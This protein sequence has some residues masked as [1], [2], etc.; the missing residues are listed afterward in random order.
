MRQSTHIWQ[1]VYALACNSASVS[2]SS[3]SSSSSSSCK[4][5]NIWCVGLNYAEHVKELGSVAAT[6]NPL[7]FLKAGSSMLA[8]GAE[9]LLPSWSEN[10]HH[11][12]ELAIEVDANLQPVR[13]AVSLDLTARDV[14]TQLKKA[15][16]PWT[17]A[18]SFPGSTPVGTPFSLTGLDVQKLELRLT[19]NGAVR[20][21]SSTALMLFDVKTLLKY[22][23]DHLPVVPGDL[24]LTGTPHGVS[25]LSPGDKLVAEVLSA[26]GKVLSE[27]SWQVVRR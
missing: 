24:V 11:E 16:W 1:R 4:P 6:N 9:L 26:D 10:V 18:K 17:L 22:I 5:A 23:K 21:Q 25:A 12:V 27:G 14:Q 3:S 2:R 13:G 8:N 15:G 20:Q 19:V 7:I